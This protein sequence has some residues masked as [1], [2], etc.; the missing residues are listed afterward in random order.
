MNCQH[1]Y[2]V[3]K[4]GFKTLCE[5]CGDYLHTCLNCALYDSK[6]DRCRSLTTEAVK[7]RKGNNY[8]EEFVPNKI[9]VLEEDSGEERTS[10]DFNALFRTGGE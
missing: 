8:C 2:D 10:E 5:N 9:S 1:K 4:V 6:V 3:R 7:D